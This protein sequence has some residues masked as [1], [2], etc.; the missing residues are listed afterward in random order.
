MESLLRRGV[1]ALEKLAAEE[2]PMEIRLETKP[3]VCP[4]CD[5]INPTVR[6][7]EIS[8]TGPLVE[9]VVQAHC[10]HCNQVFYVIPFQ[11]DCVPT[12]ESAQQIIS[13]KKR[14]GGYEGEN[15]GTPVGQ[16]AVGAS[17]L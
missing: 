15:Q 14:L 10:T 2:E 4:H 6:V 11:M 5:Q 12:I 17:G 13:T 3:P 7:E 16:D 9:Y 8:A 1:E